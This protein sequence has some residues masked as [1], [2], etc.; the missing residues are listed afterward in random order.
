[1]A[2]ES[3]IP[4]SLAGALG[5]LPT[6]LA[7][8]DPILRAV[9]QTNVLLFQIL[10]ALNP[11]ATGLPGGTLTGGATSI[12]TQIQGAT[13]N[14]MNTQESTTVTSEATLNPALIPY[15]QLLRP[16]N[17][18]AY[19]TLTTDKS[20]NTADTFDFRAVVYWLIIDN[21]VTGA[22]EISVSFDGGKNYKVIEKGSTLNLSPY[23]TPADLT[24]IMVKSA[25]ASSPF[26]MLTGESS[27]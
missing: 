9:A 12:L 3:P 17:I 2:A 18:Q 6:D 16:Q 4:K 25:V 5:N 7:S 15:F 26:E 8:K 23:S 24:S 13:N 20:P 11:A 10:Q 14:L 1:M 21:N 19:P 22:N 27:S